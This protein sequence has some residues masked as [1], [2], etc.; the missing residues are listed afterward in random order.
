[1]T[2]NVLFFSP[3][4][5]YSLNISINV[6][7]FTTVAI[8]HLSSVMWLHLLDVSDNTLVDTEAAI[9]ESKSNIG[10]DYGKGR[11]FRETK[12]KIGEKKFRVGGLKKERSGDWNHRYFFFNLPK[13]NMKMKNNSIIAHTKNSFH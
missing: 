9:A 12:L 4:L 8:T 5:R 11:K 1:M 2:L 13:H 7:Q 3:K 6:L 10:A